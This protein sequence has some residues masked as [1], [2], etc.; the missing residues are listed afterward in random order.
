[1]ANVTIQEFFSLPDQDGNVARKSDL[2]T[3][4]DTTATHALDDRSRYVI[5]S[6]A[7]DCRI[8]W[9]GTAAV[10]SDENILAAIAQAFLLAPGAGR[11]LK[12][13]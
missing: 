4:I 6:A 2:K 7:V 10:D 12:F 11:T 13:L 8:S 9:D 5:I 3:T 1:M